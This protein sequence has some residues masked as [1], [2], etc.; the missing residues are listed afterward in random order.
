MRTQLVRGVRWVGGELATYAI[1]RDG[2]LDH[3]SIVTEPTLYLIE[4]AKHIESMHS[5]R[6]T[7]S[8]LKF[9]F[10]ALDQA[11]RD[12]RDLTDNDLSAYI[13]NSLIIDRGLERP[14]IIRNTTSIAGFYSFATDFGLTD[15]YFSFTFSYRDNK[16]KLIEQGDTKRRKNYRLNQ[17]YINKELF[18]VL[19][20]N[21]NET[22]GFLRRRDETVLKLGYYA[23]LRAFE[24]THP[25]NLKVDEI[26]NK[27]AEA[28]RRK[29]ISITLPI[30]GKGNKT[31][32]VDFPTDLISHIDS[33]IRNERE[34]TPGNHLICKK[35]GE[36]LCESFA[37]R[38][39]SRVKKSSMPALINKIQY[40]GKMEDAPYT[41][42]TRSAK[43]L[44]FHCLRHTYSS[45]LVTY[46]YLH[47]IDPFTYLPNQLGHSDKEVSEIYVS[48]EASLHNREWLRRRHSEIGE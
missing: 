6:A 21:A 44:R 13:E 4:K 46:C 29:S 1:L 17:K 3:G 39:F 20:Y 2:P 47:N 42:S 26:Q 40:L 43:T 23:G 25:D 38:L 8:D 41:I 28:E 36:P 45:N 32:H 24:V 22:S 27:L 19:I 7:A 35:N 12:W 5:L 37:S 33:F 48:F 34:K 9:F 10:E 15:K 18:E 11:G 16:N 30:F 14:S 31:R